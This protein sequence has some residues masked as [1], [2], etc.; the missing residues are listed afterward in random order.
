MLGIGNKSKLKTIM[1]MGVGSAILTSIFS[2]VIIT[3][4]LGIDDRV[5]NIENDLTKAKG[6]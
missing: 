2:G 1:W 6:R 4:V 3:K 5:K